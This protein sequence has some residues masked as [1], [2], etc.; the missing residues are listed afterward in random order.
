MKLAHRLSVAA[1]ACAAL[2]VVGTPIAAG[3]PASDDRGFIDSTARCAAPSSA[4]MFG[5]TASSRV[6]IC[7]EPDGTYQYRGVRV[8]DGARL[9]TTAKPKGDGFAADN[10]GVTYT[11]T[12][13]SLV[14]AEGGRVLRE[15]RM[16]EFEKRSTAPAAGATT[17]T[18]TPTRTTPLPP[19]LAAE[20]GGSGS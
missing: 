15:E 20:V 9:I 3:A 2:L 11:M 19:P 12:S 10:H 5:R 7:A 4:V 8:R 18:P 14:V 17:S 6:A 16:V 1:T 13:D